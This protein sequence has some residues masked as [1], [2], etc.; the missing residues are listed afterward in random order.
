MG[1]IIIRFNPELFT[2]LFYIKK[3]IDDYGKEY[4]AV[5]RLSDSTQP[6]YELKLNT[7]FRSRDNS[8]KIEKTSLKE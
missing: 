7:S 4:F 1:D 6:E 5:R 3:R 8:R 2:K